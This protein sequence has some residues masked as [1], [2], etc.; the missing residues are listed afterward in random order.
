MS[1]RKKKSSIP[2]RGVN[3]SDLKSKVLRELSRNPSKSYNYKQL[4]ASIGLK[5]PNER[6]MLIQAL[7]NLKAEQKLLEPQRGV[8]SLSEATTHLQGKISFARSGVA[9]VI[10]EGMEQDV[11]ISPRNNKHSLDG[12]IVKVVIFSS[13]KGKRPEGEVIEIVERKR[14]TF[15]GVLELSRK[16][17]FVVPDN[18]KISVDIFIPLDKLN[19]A[20]NGQKVIA[21][22]TDWP[23]TADSP[24][25]EIT[26]ILGMPG[27]METEMHAI[28]SEYGLPYE[29]PEEVQQAA[30]QMDTTITADE[31]SKRRDMR[32][33][34][35]FTIDPEDAKD[36]DDALSL[37]TL[38]DGWHE[39]GIHIADVS[40]YLQPGTTL[41]NEAYERGTSVYLVDRVVPM[42][43]EVLSN[44]A[45]SLRP[46]EEKLCFSAIFEMND[47]GSIRKQWF[48]RTV[49]LSDR[50]FTY[51]EAQEIIEGKEGD[52]QSEILLMDSMAKKMRAARMTEGAITF[53][54]V[55]V[56]FRLDENSH[57]TGVFFKIS[58]DANKLI[59]EF[60]LLANRKVAEFIGKQETLKKSFV[61]RVH[62]DP[63]DEKLN[64][65][66]QFLKKFGYNLRLGSRKIISESLNKILEEVKGKGEAN[67]VE[68]LAIR[69]MSKAIYTTENIGHYGL[70]FDYYTHFTS[71][72][73]RYPDVLVHRLL[74]EYLDGG[75]ATDQEKLE[76]KCK[77]T[78]EREKTAAEAERSSIKYM[79]VEYMRDKVGH[80]FDGV[81]SGVTDYGMFVELTES[82]CEG[83][84]RIAN[85]EDD[86]YVFDEK[87]YC[88]KGNLSGNTFQLGDTLRVR[89]KNA[90]LIRKQLDFELAIGEELTSEINGEL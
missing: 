90:D 19:G 8:F 20:E 62:D 24:F 63:D 39:I 22:M 70:S 60:M 51:E 49:I 76:F 46:N 15:V 53:D 44:Q 3:K 40:H 42:L 48:G 25:G 52:M 81:I 6:K 5:D 89:V 30:D 71:P 68:T 65:F 80:V 77:H 26:E 4:C 41:D 56:K 9:F 34:T 72:I 47:E 61:Y 67:M 75:K 43:P 16:H 11:F 83:L 14:E 64:N 37:Q 69:S 21:K 88:I 10:I 7:G 85:I 73:R 13:K 45:C 78:S 84:I 31:I 1:K 28:L 12:D 74:Q 50:R 2:R 86:F 38:D 82:R 35:T 66:S 87:N 32:E 23:K 54:K 29:F 33:V 18:S 59:E 79:Q 36:F 55:E 57:P 58:K 17:A 27:E